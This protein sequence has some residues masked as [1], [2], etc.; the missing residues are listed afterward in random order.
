MPPLLVV[1]DDPDIVDVVR[2]NFEREGFRVY[3]AVTGERGLEEARRRKPDLILLDL[4]L[5]GID[6]LEICRRLRAA[7]DTKSI[8]V[9]VLTAKSEESDIVVGLEQAAA[10]AERAVALAPA[11]AAGW[12]LVADIESARGKE[13]AAARARRK[14]TVQ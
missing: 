2:Y 13:A 12:A 5:P 11:S 3:S 1:E 9:I 8:P 6:G 14:A 4:M 7:E 10:H